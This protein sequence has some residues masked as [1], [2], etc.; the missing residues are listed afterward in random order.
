MKKHI[1]ILEKLTL[2]RHAQA[3]ASIYRR[4]IAVRVG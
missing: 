3:L 4:T 1:I 2:A